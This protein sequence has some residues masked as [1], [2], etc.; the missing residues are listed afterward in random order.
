MQYK[1]LANTNFRVPEIGLGTWEYRGGVEPLQK[2]LSLGACLIDTAEIYGTEEIVG[3]AIEGR[4]HEVFLATKVAPQHFDYQ[5]VLTAAHNSLKRLG[6]DYIDLYQLHWPSGD[7][8]I[9]ETMAAM[10]KLV[11]AGKI[12]FIGVSNFSLAQ[13]KEAQS[14]TENKIVSNQVRYNLVDRRIEREL[15]PYC[16]KNNVTIIA[17]SPLARGMSNLRTKLGRRALEEVARDAGK[18]EAQMALNW[19][20]ARDNVIAIPKSNSTQ[21]TAENCQASGWRLTPYQMELLE[22]STRRAVLA[23]SAR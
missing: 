3:R 21:R 7:I 15:M 17:Y 18:T 22:E 16:H 20:T 14:V 11:S 6:A 10:D 8:P 1:K 19:C 23:G 13:L 5:S 2:G 4:R 9:E 12:R